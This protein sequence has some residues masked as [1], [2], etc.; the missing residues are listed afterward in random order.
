MELAPDPMIPELQ[1][2]L[3]GV[4]VGKPESLTDQLRWILSNEYLFRSNLYEA[5]IGEKIEAMVREMLGGA[6]AV[7][8]TL[9]HYL[10][11]R[12]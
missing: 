6:G 1:A 3:A 8:K 2:H 12:A 7:R 9:R 11:P 5:G 10:N 4:V